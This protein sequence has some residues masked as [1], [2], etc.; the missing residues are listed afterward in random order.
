M[1]GEMKMGNEV[2]TLIAELLFKCMKYQI[3]FHYSPGNFSIDLYDPKSKIIIGME[4][5]TGSHRYSSLETIK[6][7]HQKL[8]NHIKG[9]VE[10]CN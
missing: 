7:L 10:K 4:Q 9:E 2:Q 5:I 6:M 3:S 1:R 8:D